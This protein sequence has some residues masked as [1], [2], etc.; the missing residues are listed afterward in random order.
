[1]ATP[2]NAATPAP[3]NL[4]APLVLEALAAEEVLAAPAADPVDVG[5]AEVEVTSPALVDPAGVVEAA[6]EEPPMGAVD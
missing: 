3:A 6:A 2:A 4:T 1:M 5:L